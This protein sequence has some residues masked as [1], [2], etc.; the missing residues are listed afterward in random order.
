MGVQEVFAANVR[1][2]RIAAGLTQEELAE[3][4]G[5]HR[6]YIG[7]IEQNRGNVTLKSIGKIADALGVDPAVLLLDGFDAPPG[8]LRGAWESFEP[9]SMY[10]LVHWD[11][12]GIEAEPLEVHHR[13]LTVQVLLDLL[14]RGLRGP[15]LADAYRDACAEI[16]RFLDGGREGNAGTRPHPAPGEPA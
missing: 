8:R 10:A 2:Y 15:Q 11:G 4:A 6:T 13:D 16:A 3:V 1:R 12:A 7:R 5:L 14:A 9:Q